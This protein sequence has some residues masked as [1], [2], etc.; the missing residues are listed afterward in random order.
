MKEDWWRR[1]T[2]MRVI[3]GDTLVVRV[4]LGFSMTVEMKLRLSKVNCPETSTQAGRDAR[5]YTI[6]WWTEHQSHGTLVADVAYFNIRYDGWD[7]YGGRFD[8]ELTCMEGHSLNDDLLSS[9][10]AVP[11]R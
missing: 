1:G 6:N 2:I 3:D 8:G 5:I 7:N 9:G 4:D 11:Y 10:H